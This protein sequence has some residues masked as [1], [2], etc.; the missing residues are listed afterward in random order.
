MRI[1]DGG[2]FII[3]PETEQEKDTLTQALQLAKK[4][5][6]VIKKFV[7]AHTAEPWKFTLEDGSEIEKL[8]LIR[9]GE[10]DEDWEEDE[11]KTKLK[12]S[13]H[14]N[15]EDKIYEYVVEDGTTWSDWA[16]TTYDSASG[17]FLFV[18][19]GT[20]VK[21]SNSS[22]Y[23]I[24]SKGKYVNAS[25]NIL[26]GDYYSESSKIRF[27]ID[28]ISYTAIVGMTW[29][30]WV[31]SDNNTG[32]FIVESSYRYIAKSWD[33]ET[34]T[35]VVV[36]KNGTTVHPD[37]TIEQDTYT[38]IEVCEKVET[39][40]FKIEGVEYEFESGMTWSA[41]LSSQYNTKPYYAFRGYV[42]P[43]DGY[44]GSGSTI[45]YVCTSDHRAVSL[46]SAISQNV[47]YTT[48]FISGGTTTNNVNFT[49]DGTSYSVPVG[50]DWAY[51]YN[52][53]GSSILSIDDEG[54]LHNIDGDKWLVFAET[55]GKC[56]TNDI[57]SNASYM[58]N[59]LRE[60]D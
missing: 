28:D 36:S 17:D 8:V 56:R 46:D 44:T 51:F 30:E 25:S 15:E 42:S 6:E 2:T 41:W 29:K 12:F 48:Y 14:I 23:I 60:Y 27:L 11:E 26:E 10:F 37:D 49:I 53:G 16:K 31:N 40:T 7:E 58:F 1:A 22:Y 47:N 50:A 54:Y 13:I 34:D 33:N 39:L 4:A 52:N 38:L 18:V 43:Y 19:D 20:R 32:G 21:R 35:G 45:I 5:K 59:E 24:D 9:T 3:L 57:I 55:Y